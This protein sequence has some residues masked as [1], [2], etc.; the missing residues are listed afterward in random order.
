MVLPDPPFAKDICVLPDGSVP[1]HCSLAEPNVIPPYPPV[2]VP[3]A[4][5][6]DDDR[7]SGP[8]KDRAVADFTFRLAVGVQPSKTEPHAPE[9]FLNKK[10]WQ[11]FHSS[12]TPL[13]F[14][15]ADA[16]VA[17]GEHHFDDPI[18]AGPLPVGSVVDLIIENTL[19]E[20]ATLYKH[21]APTWF[22]GS[23]EHGPFPHDSVYEAV[24]SSGG[25]DDQDGSTRLNLDNPG[26]HIVHD[27]PP[28][29]WSVIRFKVIAKE[30]TML[31]AVKLRHFVVSTYPTKALC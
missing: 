22:L 10:P 19:N 16:A 20:T 25:G 28:L 23:G 27:V 31:H 17:E 26:L 7:L 2:P 13:L 18:L 11:L 1:E 6:L 5:K 24:H 4:S 9:Y 30:V 8:R 21:G 29:G 15:F 12:M 14:E 3:I